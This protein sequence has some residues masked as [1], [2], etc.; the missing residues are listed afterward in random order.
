MDWRTATL[1]QSPHVLTVAKLVRRGALSSLAT[2]GDQEWCC[3]CFHG[4]VVD[5]YA[6]HCYVLGPR[7]GIVS[8]QTGKQ[9]S[10]GHI[11][12]RSIVARISRRLW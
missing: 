1:Q 11:S 7:K 5:R 8:R 4:P 6:K 9:I 12:K 10:V 3:W 2:L